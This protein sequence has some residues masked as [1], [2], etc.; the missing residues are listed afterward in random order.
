MGDVAR[1]LAE[2]IALP[3]AVPPSGTAAAARITPAVE[4]TAFDDQGRAAT[5]FSGFVTV[6]IGHDASLFGNAV[7][8]GTRTVR[9][10]NGVARFGDLSIDQSGNG[11][12]LQ[13]AAST[14][15][16]AESSAFNIS[17]L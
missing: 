17:V 7:L 16:G 9:A 11:Y 1:L 14:L 8:S 2:L 5:S 6:A 12:T 3:S 15:R 4:V 13:A 10:V